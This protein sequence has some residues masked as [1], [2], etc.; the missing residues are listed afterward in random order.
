MIVN[1]K[2]FQA[3]F[4]T[5][6][7]NALSRNLK[8]QINNTEITPQLSV[9]LLGVTTDNEL[10][11]DQH[12]S[13]LCKSVGCQLNALSRLKNYL[14]FEQKKVLYMQTLTIVH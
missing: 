6:K 14:N 3:I 4:I 10:K 12:I 11:F 8:L 9:E 2:K 1:S 13:R 5:K 7:T